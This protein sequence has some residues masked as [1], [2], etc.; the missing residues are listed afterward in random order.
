MNILIDSHVLIWWTINPEKL[1]QTAKY[2]L[3]DKTNQLLLSVVSVWEMQ[4]KIQQGKLRLDLPL[5]EIIENQV[6]YN[7]LQILTIALEDI[8]TLGTLGNYHKD[9]FDRLI[10]S[11][12]LTR[13]LPLLSIDEVFDTYNIERLW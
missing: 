5:P 6:K 11:Q 12:S 4:I 8:W 3:N 13:Q 1:S 10:I 9:P 7:D 2:L